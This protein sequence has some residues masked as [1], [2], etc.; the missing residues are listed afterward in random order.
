MI[1]GTIGI[2]IERVDELVNGVDEHL[3]SYLTSLISSWTL[4]GPCYYGGLD[5]HVDELFD[6]LDVEMDTSW[7]LLLWT[8]RFTVSDFVLE[9]GDVI[10]LDWGLGYSLIIDY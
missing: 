1:D 5:E 3:T 6:G 8:V 10:G 4:V 2:V 9:V 7:T